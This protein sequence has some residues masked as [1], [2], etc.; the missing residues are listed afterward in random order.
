MFDTKHTYWDPSGK[1]DHSFESSSTSSSSSSSSVINT[2]N[3]AENDH[4]HSKSN[5][6]LS[7]SLKKIF[8]D[9]SESVDINCYNK[10]MEY[11]ASGHKWLGGAQ[12]SWLVILLASTGATIWLISLSVI[13]FLNYDVVTQTNLVYELP[14]Q[15]PSITFC[16]N[17]AFTTY[18]SQLLYEQMAKILNYTQV[19]IVNDD[20]NH[21][22]QMAA[23]NP[24][25]GDANRK[26]LGYLN[27]SIVF[28]CKYN[29]ISCK[30]DLHWYYSFE[31]GNCWQFNVG[32]NTTDQ[33]IEVNTICI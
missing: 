10:M 12:L 13:D 7:S 6:S 32:L 3:S 15:F 2:S 31:F 4:S 29:K 16:E 11:R 22:V 18:D 25:F 30:N 26:K 8:F 5:E 23:A 17:D 21:L 1:N 19:N 14:T 24:A 33:Q 28:T 20:L 9:W 27:R